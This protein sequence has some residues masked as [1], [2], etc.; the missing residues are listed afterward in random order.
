MYAPS[1]YSEPCAMFTMRVTPKISDRPAD[2]KKSDEAF[3]RPFRAWS[4]STSSGSLLLRRPHLPDLRVGRLHYRAVDVTEVLHRPLAILDRGLADPG[5]HRPLVIDPPIH[6]WARRRI[7]AQAGESGNQLLGIGAAGLLD[8]FGKRLDGDVAHER[9]ELG[10]VIE[11]LLV[12][13]YEG[14]VFRGRD[15]V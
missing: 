6:D 14:L 15:L 12:G 5:A 13:A 7:D 1:M 8:A 3:A 4:A 9:A 10:I 11:A 2:R